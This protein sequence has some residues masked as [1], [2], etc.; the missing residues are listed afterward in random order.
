MS[1]SISVSVFVCVWVCALSTVTGKEQQQSAGAVSACLGTDC[2]DYA[3]PLY[4]LPKV[5]LARV[6]RSR[7]Q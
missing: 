3:D 1:V 6:G 2:L 4:P 7:I 5:L